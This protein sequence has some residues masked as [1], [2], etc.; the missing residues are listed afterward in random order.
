MDITKTKCWSFHKQLHATDNLWLCALCRPFCRKNCHIVNQRV[1]VCFCNWRF[2]VVFFFRSLHV[3]VNVYICG[4]LLR[5][6]R[7]P[8]AGWVWSRDERGSPMVVVVAAHAEEILIP[9]R[10]EEAGDPPRG[11]TNQPTN[12]VAAVAREE[13]K[14][15]GL[16]LVCWYSFV[17]TL[18]FVLLE[19]EVIFKIKWFIYFFY[20]KWSRNNF[21]QLV[22]NPYYL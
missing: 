6:C 21:E 4:F 7:A 2:V 15:D 11:G 1:N 22:Y 20:H 3:S 18:A 10:W 9:T 8:R 12:Q 19:N 14:A 16:I 13:H 5:N 17:I